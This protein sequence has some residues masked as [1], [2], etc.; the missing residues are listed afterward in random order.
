MRC[1]FRA[2]S[3]AALWVFGVVTATAPT[4]AAAFE[5]FGFKFFGRDD[6]DETDT[7]IG[8]PQPYTVEFEVSGDTGDEG[9]LKAAS[10]LWKERDRPA[11]GAAGLIARARGDY[12]NLVYAL[13]ASAR[14]GGT[15][16]I[17]IDGR[18]AADIPPDA[19]LSETAEV[20]IAVDPGPLF[21]FD[22]TLIRNRAP[23]PTDRK[24]TVPTP[25]SGGF[26]PGQPARSTV[27]LQAESRA[28]EAWRQQGY[29]KA[30]AGP[31][32]VTA[33]HPNETVDATLEMQPGRKAHF[34]P[35][36]VTGTERMDPRFVAYMAG[37]KPGEEFDPD[38]V[39][40][41]ST[42]LARLD[43]F[44]SLRIVE[45]E[46][47]GP[48]GSLPMHILV[49]ERKLHRIGVGGSF[50]TIDGLGLEAYWLHRNLFGRA[51]QL[52][53]EGRVSNFD[54]K[55][56]PEDFTYRAGATFTKPGVGT[57][58]SNFSASAYAEREVLDTYTKTGVSGQAGFTHQFS[59]ALQARAY[60]T[61]QHAQFEDDVY[62]TRD[63][64]TGGFLGAFTYD[65]RNNIGNPSR[66]HYVDVTALPF[67]EFNYANAAARFTAEARTY[68]GVGGDNRLILAGRAKIGT[69]FGPSIAQLPP[70]QVFFTGGGGSVRGYPYRSI[71]VEVGNNVVG[72]KSLVEG[73]VELRGR[74]TET[75]GAVAFLDA[76][77]VGANSTPDF[78]QNVKFGAGVGLR[79]FTSVGP[80]RFDVAV[81]LEKRDGDPDFAFYVGIGQAF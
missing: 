46:T 17:T 63:F 16:S 76:G 28:V 20:K 25:E 21:L 58:D 22:Q 52:R 51:E 50:S 78:D 3:L 53:I 7:V 54:N 18:Q 44:S 5:L 69:L 64:T 14:Y 24:D 80:I 30:K 19:P 2:R 75:I 68:Y 56:N 29:A 70:D 57:P 71:G 35:T 13:Y 62:G 1:S 61:G 74:I 12:R 11:S 27:I 36:D 43:V 48:D 33:N 31:R 67:Y 77:A 47:I 40:R 81:P 9:R 15:V 26:E 10:S 79:Y 34:G 49:S 55:T 41:A 73:N 60:L 42:R 32:S 59:E 37:L 45:D 72:G 65:T 6:A 8:E 39:K 4:P 66:G 23:Y 38:A